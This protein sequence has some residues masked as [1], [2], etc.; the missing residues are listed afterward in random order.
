MR[1]L[2]TTSTRRLMAAIAGVVVAIVAGSALAIAAVGSGPV[3]PKKPLAAAIHDALAAPSVNGIS[4]RIKFTN[5]LIDSSDIQGIDPL[6]SG[7]SGRM[8]LSPTQGLRIELQSDN[9]DAQIVVHKNS[10]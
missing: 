9:G 6:F 1:F 4:A 3:P 7:A 8:W 10:F 2:R 5:H